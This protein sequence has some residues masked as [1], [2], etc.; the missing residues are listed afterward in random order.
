[1]KKQA[2][3]NLLERKIKAICRRKL[4]PSFCATLQ[5]GGQ[6]TSEVKGRKK[7]SGDEP[8]RQQRCDACVHL[9]YV[10]QEIRSY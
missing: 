2:L 9:Y 5:E 6:G 8:V 7:P 3:I 4:L 1:M 10:A